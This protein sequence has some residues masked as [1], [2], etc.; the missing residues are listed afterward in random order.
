MAW[1]VG[2]VE[3]G[4]LRVRI[5]GERVERAS[6]YTSATPVRLKQF[7]EHEHRFAREGTAKLCAS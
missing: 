1:C 2:M 7:A 6:A 4:A 3:N 5:G